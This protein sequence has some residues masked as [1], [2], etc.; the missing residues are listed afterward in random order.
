MVE[1]I[2]SIL[3]GTIS[4]VSMALRKASYQEPIILGTVTSWLAFATNWLSTD[5]LGQDIGKR[6]QK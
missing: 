4:L 5:D 1:I 6:T 3:T 2:Q